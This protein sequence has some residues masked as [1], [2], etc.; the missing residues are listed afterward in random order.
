MSAMVIIV[1]LLKEF[2]LHVQVGSKLIILNKLLSIFDGNNLTKV[3]NMK[4]A[5]IIVFLDNLSIILNT[6]PNLVT[7]NIS[8]RISTT[9]AKKIKSMLLNLYH[10]LLF[11]T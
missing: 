1:N 5:L 6:I 10:L 8:L 3:S 4:I 11:S 9:T 7:N 2:F